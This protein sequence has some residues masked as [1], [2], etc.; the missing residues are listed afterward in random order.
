MVQGRG[1]FVEESR[2]GLCWARRRKWSSFAVTAWW[3]SDFQEMEPK[4][5]KEEIPD[6]KDTAAQTPPP[7]TEATNVSRRSRGIK[8]PTSP[9]EGNV[10][11]LATTTAT[12]TPPS[13]SHVTSTLHSTPPPAS[14]M[15]LSPNNSNPGSS[16]PPAAAPGGTRPNLGKLKRFLSTLV[17][18]G[19]EI[20]ADLGEKVR[21]LVFSMVNGNITIEEFHTSLQEATNFPLR[22]FVLPFLRT[23]LPLLQRE[24]SH[25]ARI[26]KQTTSQYLRHHE[27]LV[28]DP[29]FSP[30]EPS[31]I[32][33][34]DQ[35]TENGK[36]KHLDS[37]YENGITTSKDDPPSSSEPQQKRERHQ[38]HSQP[39]PLLFNSA[40]N[41]L[42]TFQ[43]FPNAGSHN[44]QFS[45]FNSHGNHQYTSG[46]NTTL[47][48][49]NFHL[50]NS[51]N[52]AAPPH[53][54]TGGEY[55]NQE[56]GA[57][58]GKDDRSGDEEWKNINTMLNC[59]LSMVE[60]TKRA[61]SILQTRDRGSTAETDM[62]RAA[63]EI[64][65]ITED[66]IAEIKRRA[67]EAVNEVKRQAMIELERVVVKS[68]KPKEDEEGSSESQIGVQN[69]C[70]NCGRKAQETCSGCNIARY[71][72]SYC[73]HRD[74][75]THHQVCCSTERRHLTLGPTSRHPSEDRR[76][77]FEERRSVLE[78][79]RNFMEEHHGRRHSDENRRFDER[80]EEK[81][82]EKEK[83]KS[84]LEKRNENCS[85]KGNN[86]SSRK[87]P[88]LGSDSNRNR[89]LPNI[90]SQILNIDNIRRIKN[91]V[92]S[93]DEDKYPDNSLKNNNSLSS[94]AGGIRSNRCNSRSTT[95]VSATS[96]VSDAQLTK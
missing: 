75:E 5:I 33:S 85:E 22:P 21:T 55:H 23:H 60:K 77:L 53:L 42:S 69:L 45:G 36:R 91:H 73:Q 44:F 88:D 34:S 74:W 35:T 71:C 20:N 38:Q 52:H 14:T 89:L 72:G 78:E 18:F 17:Q 83:E 26:A 62:K 87:Y 84:D 54:L 47:L 70:W 48:G 4:A 50:L 67:E 10:N 2:N 25:Q 66:R 3:R 11:H 58:R 9:E 19:A 37:I 40:L 64:I 28:L 29:S 1:G 96:S 30:S 76:H 95:P 93:R 59:I 92:L 41:P 12:T 90:S 43:T 49:S 16:S 39:I 8:S 65:R 79:R 81:R 63:N 7:A 31:E 56:S 6:N 51:V 32:F 86:D 82:T 61:L 57:V 46:F 80:K 94:F 24:L 68:S 27:Q 15:V 13:L